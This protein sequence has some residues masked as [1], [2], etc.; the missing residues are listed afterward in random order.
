MNNELPFSQVALNNEVAWWKKAGL[1]VLVFSGTGLVP[2]L[3]DSIS[4]SVEIF[5]RLFNINS[6][7]VPYAKTYVGYTLAIP[8]AITTM[9]SVGDVEKSIKKLRDANQQT[10]DLGFGLKASQYVL[11]GSSFVIASAASSVGVLQRWGK[12][13][14]FYIFAAYTL[15]GQMSTILLQAN[16]RIISSAD[17]INQF[18]LHENKCE[19]IKRSWSKP[20]V[21]ASINTLCNM[22]YLG[23]LYYYIG[24]IFSQLFGLP[25]TT[26]IIIST[27]CAAL[28]AYMSFTIQGIN[29]IYAAYQKSSNAYRDEE[30]ELIKNPSI[31]SLLLITFSFL[32]RTTAVIGFSYSLMGGETVSND[33]FN[34]LLGIVA[35]T[36]IL[37]GAASATQYVKYIHNQVNEAIYSIKDFASCK[38]ITLFNNKQPS[39]TTVVINNSDYPTESSSLLPR[40]TA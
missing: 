33:V 5:C 13:W 38:R 28:G 10:N 9:L 36:M 29:E 17:L 6:P 8:Y 2:F 26:E 18:I 23:A 7:F 25:R 20:V 37:P 4:D 32:C 39:Q 14:P 16:K 27:V 30:A 24:A 11:V 15:A 22:I 34:K 3:A 12:T 1:I 40:I 19:I 31:L 21:M 35:L